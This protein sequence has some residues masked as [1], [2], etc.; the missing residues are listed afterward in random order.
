[1]PVLMRVFPQGLV[2]HESE[3]FRTLRLAYEEWIERKND[4]AIHRAWIK[5]VL[6]NTL[7]L[8]DEV[9][10][11]GQ[12]VMLQATIPA[13]G[14]TLRPDYIIK[15]PAGAEKPGKPR[16]LVCTYPASQNL[17]RP[18]AGR[19]WKASPDT[20]MMELLHRTNCRL[21]LVTNGEHWMLVDAP[22]GETTGYI[23]WYANLWLDENITLRA[24]RS[25]LDV[26]RFFSV[27]DEDILETMLAES[28]ANQQEVTDQLGY[29]VRNAVEVLVQSLDRADQD[30]G[31]KLLKHITEEEL[32]EAALTVMMRLVFLFSAEERELL[33]LDDPLYN[34]NY[35]VSTLRASLRETAD[36]QTEDV[37]E[38]RRDAWC[39]LLSTFRSV[40]G[41]IQHERLTLPAYGGHLLDPDRFPFLEGREKGTTWRDTPA[42]PLPINNRTV[43][44]LLEALQILQV[45]VPGGG[46]AEARLLS[47][48]ALDIEQIGHVYEGL[49]D[50]TAKRAR[51][52]MLGFGGSKNKEP[53]IPLSALEELR[54]KGEKE[55]ID[56]LKAETGRTANP[57][58]KALV[59]PCAIEH[60]NRCKVTGG[61]DVL[62]NRVQPY[63]NLIRND[64]FGRPVIIREGSVFVTAGT[65]RRSSGTHYTP[66]SLTQPIVK[67]TLDPLCYVGP[68]EG[69]PEDEWQ[70]RSARELLDLKICDMACG[71]GAFLVQACR[72]LSELLVEAWEQAEKE[73]PGKVRITPHGEPSEGE[74]SDQPIPLDT[75]ERLTYARRII[76]A[77][78][79]YGV[80]MNPL[81]VEMAK[82]SLW[83][84]TLAKDKPFEFLDHAIRCGDSLV[85]LHDLE[86]LRHYSLKPAADDLV[87]FK[88]PLDSAVDEAINLRLKLE[89]MPANTVEDVEAQEK[90]LTEAE[91]KIAR[92]RCAADVLVAAEFW[93]ENAKDKQERLRAAAV[94]SDHYVEYGPTKEFEVKAVEKRRGQKMFH[95]PLEFPE[96]IVKRG[97]FNAF[98]GNPPFLG[99]KYWSS[100]VSPR[101][102]DFSFTI[103]DTKPGHSDICALFHRRALPLLSSSGACGLI[104]PESLREGDSLKVGL[105]PIATCSTIYRAYSSLRWPGS[106]TV[107]VC[108][109]WSYKGKYNGNFILDGS[110]VEAIDGRLSEL[111]FKITP[112]ALATGFTAG[113]GCHNAKGEMLI[114]SDNDVWRK[115]LQQTNSP[116]LRRYVT[117]DDMADHGF[118]R[119]ERFVVYTSD[120]SFEEVEETSPITAEFLNKVVRPVRTQEYLKSFP[121]LYKRW[122][123]FHRPAA[124]LYR[125]VGEHDKYLVIGMVTKYVVPARI[126]SNW[127]STNKLCVFAAD[128]YGVFGLLLCS[129]TDVW[130]RTMSGSLGETLS[131]SIKKGV[132]TFPF[133]SSSVSHLHG[134]EEAV[135]ALHQ[136]LLKQCGD[137]Y[138]GLYNRFHDSNET[139]ANLQKLRELHVEMDQGVA[140][141]YGWDDLDLGHGFHETKQGLR[142][143][144]NESARREVLLRLLK[145]N[146]E[147]YEEE[148][149][150]GLHDKKSK[151]KVTGK[152][153]K[154]KSSGTPLFE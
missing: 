47:F 128:R 112:H 58:K 61:S 147:R 130:I 127:I 50:H 33:P 76:A 9:I 113:G 115:R 57:L 124:D 84:L 133:P 92:L 52:P 99:N 40:H 69:K 80:D 2:G 70:L 88:G 108:M 140:A 79:L 68:A 16:L 45:K 90:L 96:V 114:L 122:W 48:R 32:Y 101:L 59:E 123:Q 29:Q 86:Q 15:N 131:V 119:C 91:D 107:R 104:G 129:F 149:K 82:L 117:N 38:R 51:E 4:P 28:A 148:V 152:R 12:A 22:I 121:G 110:P 100:A 53:E 5:F 7:E 6:G 1:M 14:E 73:L 8:P 145:L 120:S 24:F 11:E 143:T 39:R 78:C 106:A 153:K 126:P 72:Y 20:R 31:G 109:V 136:P 83:L 62:W 25:L 81:A 150:Q 37:L 56:F 132:H 125:K 151:R 18:V 139:A 111:V 94:L 71:S 77:R 98:V 89:N 135:E 95:W 13:H 10:D 85:G 44:H 42:T 35:A 102:T 23:S 21:G 36:Q 63:A 93:G 19:H 134:I 17:E 103:L 138:T 141:A 66:T 49:L 144:I 116:Y 137:G 54:T 146:H 75:E 118:L 3:H 43:L 60:A 41:G 105:N 87:L 142:Y 67:H 46:R 27:P 154:N 64:T 97:G 55:L 26:R 65:D 74:P 34:Q 30:R